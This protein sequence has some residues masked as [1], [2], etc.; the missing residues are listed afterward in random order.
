MELIRRN[1]HMDR[2]KTEAVMQFTAEEDVNVSDS[3]PDV[4]AINLERGEVILEEIRPTAGQVFVK[5]YLG[6]TILYHTLD[7]GSR[8]VVLEGRLPFS[9]TMNVNGVTASDAVTV[10]GELQDLSI[11][12]INSRKLSIQSLITLTA[13]VEELYDEEAPVGVH[14]EERVEY[15][16]VPMNVAQIVI[17]KH[18]I[19]RWKK[20]LDMPAGYPNISEILWND[21]SLRDMQI[22][23]SDEKLL[24]TGE[25][26]VFL[27]YEGEGE[28]KP[29]LAY[30]TVIPISG[31]IDCHGCRE[32]M[33]SDIHWA[34]GQKDVAVRPDL[35]GEERCVGIEL[36]LEF[37]MKVYEDEKLE[38]I[39]DLYGV[40][41]E[42]TSRYYDATLRQLL[43]RVTGKSKV[44]DKIKVKSGNVLQLLH[45]EGEVLQEQQTVVPNGILLR[46]F[47]KL[48][49]MYITGTDDMPYG[50]TV[51]MIPYEYT[52]E[53]PGITTEDKYSVQ[54]EVEQ[55]QVSMLDGE[56][57]DVK[58]VLGFSTIVFKTIPARLL[59]TVEIT[60][61]SPEKENRLPGIAFYVVKEGDN[62][63]N[64]G[65]RYYIS[66][67]KLKELN[68]LESD[69]LQIGQKLLIVRG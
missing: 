49:V 47:L 8:L 58:A 27:L 30:E 36:V 23:P 12:M 67:D 31:T 26:Q 68:A 38:V 21:V 25:V 16:K 60:A 66:V 13:S 9:E 24:L 28:N 54:G 11:H 43:T 5:G 65:K 52:L 45:S 19:F 62:L 50:S 46:G 57:M 14:G 44:A 22:R 18:D 20:E 42:V 55:L 3:K 56:E 40:S 59:N 53:V 64:I 34:V 32:G 29:V 37:G 51:E 35:D 61:L 33:I 6:Y 63:W 39:S 17:S 1:I 4:N 41:D 7:G 10:T 48:K 15:H 69:E 2:V